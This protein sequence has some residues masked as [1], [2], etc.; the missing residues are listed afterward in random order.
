MVSGSQFEA[1]VLR[2]RNSAFNLAYWILQN[3]EDVWNFQSIGL[4]IMT[5]LSYKLSHTP[6]REPGFL[7][8]KQAEARWREKCRWYKA[9][10]RFS[11]TFH[12]L[13]P[14]AFA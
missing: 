12:H 14:V 2:H 8:L 7:N 3:R 9:A 1:L 6:H 5:N 10:L 13:Y 11:P 4:S